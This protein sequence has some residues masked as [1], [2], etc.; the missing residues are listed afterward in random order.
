VRRRRK[1][2][3]AVNLHCAMHSYR[4]GAWKTAVARGADNANWFAFTGIQS[5]GHGPQ[6]PIVLS[7]ANASHPIVK[8]LTLWT[9][10]NE[11]LYN[12]LTDFDV[13]PIL[14]GQQP[15]AANEKERDLRYTVAWTHEYGPAKAKVFSLTLA[16]NE[17][18]MADSRYL[19][20]VARAAAWATGH[21]TDDG[22]YD[23]AIRRTQ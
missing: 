6:S 3:P 22:A 1:G 11:E 4:S 13:T 19:D 17:S 7:M 23:A 16:H 2:I 18:T 8:G 9:T 12:N 14:S 20:L 21:L 5:T 10:P 15:Q